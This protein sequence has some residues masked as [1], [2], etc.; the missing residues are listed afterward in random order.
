LSV[1]KIFSRGYF[2]DFSY[3][4][5]SLRGNYPGLFRN[6][7]GQLDPNI[8]SEYDLV[9]LLPNR[10]G[11]LPGDIPNSF[12][13]DAGYA[14]EISPGTSLQL[15]GSFRA[16]QGH[17]LNYLGAHP[18]YGPAE[19]YILPRGS[20]GR[21]PWNWEIDVRAAVTRKLWSRYSG[22]FSLDI[23]NLTNNRAVTAA[24]EQYTTDS[25]YPI[26]N[27]RPA[28]LPFLK[29]VA[30]TTAVKNAAFLSP[31]GYQLPLSVRLGARV[32]F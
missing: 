17:P 19:A 25:V 6:E 15:G 32:S 3:T 21:L 16:D 13:A 31:T 29:T 30:G 5:S 8:L 11:P 24:N 1:R 22:T 28:D 9:S 2:L 26:V 18:L 20:A 12:K 7:N 10:D 4:Y 23:F 27:G 14:L